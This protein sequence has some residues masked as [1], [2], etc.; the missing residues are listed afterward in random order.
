MNGLIIDLRNHRG[1]WFM[2][3][4][5]SLSPFLNNTTLFAW[6]DKKVNPTQKKW[7]NF[8]KNKLVFQSKIINDGQIHTDIP[9]AII[10]G[11]KTTSSG[12]ICASIFYRRS[13]KI[14]TFGNNTRGLLSTNGDF[15]ITPILKFHMPCSLT[16]TIDGTFHINQYLKPR[17]LTDTP[18]S[19]ANKWIIQNNL[20]NKINK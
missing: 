13:P 17:V 6:N 12:E 10:I 8:I 16:T 15:S 20:K 5:I 1:G 7:I 2:P 9:I 11:K 14:Q 18:I 19:D 3:F 4:V